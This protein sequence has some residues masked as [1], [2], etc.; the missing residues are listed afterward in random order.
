MIAT[1]AMFFAG[2]HLA[3]MLEKR[4][5][6]PQQSFDA[7]IEDLH[8]H[9]LIAGFGRVGQTV[10]KVLADA[11][12]SYLAL[13]LDQ[14]RVA[15]CRAKGMSVYFGDANQIQVLQAAGAERAR[16][17]VVTLDN[18]EAT[19]R[20]VAALRGDCPDLPIYVRA[21]DRRH[22]RSLETVGATAVVSEAA[23]SSLQLGSIVLASLD[24]SADE[25]A[26]VI[27]EYREGD[28]ARLEDII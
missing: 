15:K 12:I 27:Q 2:K 13:D 9:V 16:T 19:S 8:S 23:E 1:P 14:N 26:C 11:G 10:A 4:S 3:C 21:R 18:Q 5:E 28:Y 7:D 20:T 22:M 17:A 25:I 24:V 6:K